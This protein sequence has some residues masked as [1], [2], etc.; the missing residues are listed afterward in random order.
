MGNYRVKFLRHRRNVAE[1]LDIQANDSEDAINYVII[2]LSD[3]GLIVDVDY[4]IISVGEF[5]LIDSEESVVDTLGRT[6]DDF[7]LMYLKDKPSFF[8]VMLILGIIIIAG[9]FGMQKNGIIKD[10]D[11]I[12]LNDCS[13]YC[14]TNNAEFKSSFYDSKIKECSCECLDFK[15]EYDCMPICTKSC[16][17]NNKS[18][19][20]SK[21]DEELKS[22]SCECN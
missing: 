15:S 13:D 10:K 11:S 9:I 12:C 8:G 5:G 16:I 19:S 17:E 7:K 1:Y 4:S 2:Q 6:K 20:F 18:L 21:Y 22:C 14:L 3:N